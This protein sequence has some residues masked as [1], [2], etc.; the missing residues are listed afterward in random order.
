LNS[1]SWLS[2]LPRV[3]FWSGEPLGE[4]L[5]EGTQ[6]WNQISSCE[7]HQL[8]LAVVVTGLDAIAERSRS[9]PAGTFNSDDI[10]ESSARRHTKANASSCARV[11]LAIMFMEFPSAPIR[12]SY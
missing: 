7:L 4:T 12:C 10:A 9:T 11:S 8:A 3:R 1:D 6:F 2:G 5:S